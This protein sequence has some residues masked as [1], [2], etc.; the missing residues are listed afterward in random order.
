MIVLRRDDLVSCLQVET[1]GEQR[2]PCPRA[3][4]QH[5]IAGIRAEKLAGRHQCLTQE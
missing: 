4:R 2:Q 3:A 5:E 1:R